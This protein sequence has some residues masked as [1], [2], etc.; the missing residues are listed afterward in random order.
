MSKGDKCCRTCGSYTYYGSDLRGECS[1]LINC[2]SDSNASTVFIIGRCP[3]DCR[4]PDLEDCEFMAVPTFCCS[5]W[6]E[7][8][9]T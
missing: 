2:I 7:R 5:E 3:D 1:A 4:G 6:R 8:E 9:E